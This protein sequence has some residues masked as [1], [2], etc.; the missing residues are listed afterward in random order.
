MATSSSGLFSNM[1]SQVLM[2][3]GD[4]SDD[5]RIDY[6]GSVV[7]DNDV[8]IVDGKST[9]SDNKSTPTRSITVVRRLTTDKNKSK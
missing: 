8:E 6:D 7:D 5:E 9:N 1:R 2:H 3:S 4:Y